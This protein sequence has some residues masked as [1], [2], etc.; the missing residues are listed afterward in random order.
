MLPLAMA[1]IACQTTNI[2][3]VRFYTEIPFK[4]CPEG[5]YVDSVTKEKGLI[6]CEEW[7]TKRPFMLMVDPEGKKQIFGQWLEA[8]HWAG[9][10][11][12]VQLDSVKKTVEKLDDIAG[13]VIGIIK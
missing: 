5:V 11:C 12:N 2:P 4:D 10:K 6:S 8:C 1:L 13:K 3:N 9:E 7:K